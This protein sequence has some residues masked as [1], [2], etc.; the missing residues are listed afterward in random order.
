MYQRTLSSQPE[1]VINPTR[2]M[3]EKCAGILGRAFY[4]DLLFNYAFPDEKTRQR[5]LLALFMLNVRYGFKYGDVYWSDG[6]GLAIWFPPGNSKISIRRALETGMLVTPIKI[7]LSAVLRLSRI[8]VLSD[9][10]HE[11]FAPDLHWYLFLLGVDPTSQG[12]GFGRSLLQPVINK[13]DTEH[14]PCYLETNNPA[15]VAF[16]RKN[17]FDVVA[18]NQ[19]KSTD[20]FVW[21]M[22]RESR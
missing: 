10:M 15:A 9:L 1:K 18:E 6:Q 21:G 7:G 5:R 11:R 2:E 16:Y 3:I 14:L 19:P 4:N 13:A 20:F 17:G 22:R 12:A 8:N